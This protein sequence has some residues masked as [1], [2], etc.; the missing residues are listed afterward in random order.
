MLCKPTTKEIWHIDVDP[1][2]QQMPVFYIDAKA[3][4]KAD[5]ETFL[6]QLNNSV[7]KHVTAYSGEYIPTFE[8][9]ETEFQERRQ[10]I[11]MLAE[12]RKDG[13][14]STAYVTKR[15]KAAVPKDTVYCVEA[16]TQTGKLLGPVLCTVNPG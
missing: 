7:A 15:L 13:A 9:L 10:R 6:K 1:M 14:L 12:P 11:Q 16:V 4:F 5:A 2:K 3:R 8:A